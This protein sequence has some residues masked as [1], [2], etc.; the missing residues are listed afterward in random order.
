MGRRQVTSCA[1]PHPGRGWVSRLARLLGLCALVLSLIPGGARSSSA[2]SQPPAFLASAPAPDRT[3][4][5]HTLHAAQLMFIENVGQFDPDAR[6]QV[7][8][9][10]ARYGWQKLCCGSR[11]WSSRRGTC[12]QTS[13]VFKTSE[14]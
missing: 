5:V 11:C 10:A 4:A 9:A 3:S 6:F 12:T 13:E 7:Q 2:Q 8:G 14:V 1:L